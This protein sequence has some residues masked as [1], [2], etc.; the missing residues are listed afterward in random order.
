MESTPE[1]TVR[2]T[3]SWAQF[4]PGASADSLRVESPDADLP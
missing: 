3:A 2:K 1:N 4:A